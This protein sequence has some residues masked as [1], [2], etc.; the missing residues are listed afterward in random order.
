VAAECPVDVATFLLNEKRND[1]LTIEAAGSR[2]TCCWCRIVH[3]ET[4]NYSIERLRHDDLNQGEPL[5]MSFDMV[6]QPEQIDPAQQMKEEAA[7]PRQEAMVKGITPAQPAPLP[8]AK[9]APETRVAS[10]Q[11]TETGCRAC[12]T[13]S[14]R[15]PSTRRQA[16]RPRRREDGPPNAAGTD[17][18]TTARG[19]ERDRPRGDARRGGEPRRDE[20]AMRAVAVTSAATIEAKDVPTASAVNRSNARDSHKARAAATSGATPIARTTR[21]RVSRANARDPR[22]GARA[23]RAT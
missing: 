12:S 20:P 17:A 14:A 10:L 15:N 21:S 4:P 6:K 5:P 11:R 16:P 7:A 18:A 8:V 9:P 19:D 13:G 23:A 1:V 2:S 3:L 22:T